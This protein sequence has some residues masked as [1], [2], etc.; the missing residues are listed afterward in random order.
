MNVHV[1]TMQGNKNNAIANDSSKQQSNTENALQKMAND[2][3]QV[4]QL[5]AYHEM[6]NSSPQ[7]KQLRAYQQMADNAVAQ[8]KPVVQR[9]V[10]TVSKDHLIN[11]SAQT[12]ANVTRAT[13]GAF[14]E[15]RNDETI[16]IFAH[17]YHSLTMPMNE[18]SETN[19]EPMLEGGITAAQ[20]CQMMIKEGWSKEHTGAID[21]RAC[22]SGAESML[23]SFAELF[24]TELKK[25]GR[26][27]IV[28]GYKHLTKT[29]NDGSEKAMKPTI[30]KMITVAKQFDPKKIQHRFFAESVT[31]LF[32]TRVPTLL[33]TRKKFNAYK[34]MGAKFF[35]GMPSKD[36]GMTNEEWCVYSFYHAVE[37]N[38]TDLVT[39][40]NLDFTQSLPLIDSPVG[41]A[42][43]RQFNPA[44]MVVPVEEEQDNSMEEMMKRLDALNSKN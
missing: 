6:A 5:R 27:N 35:I 32:E 43:G 30:G 1:D 36:W 13:A 15:V 33:E 10:I 24:A 28:T 21:I 19:L 44:D 12:V 4:N 40:L 11:D 41:G 9:A 2:S 31:K 39:I 34:H 17:G 20:L 8:N 3:Q 38:N 42:H 26:S 22:M 29:E 7:V 18:E 14:R 16:Y 37:T 23:P 25:A